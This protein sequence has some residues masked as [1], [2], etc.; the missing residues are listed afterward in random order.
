[1]VVSIIKVKDEGEALRVAN[2]ASYGLSAAV[3]TRDVTFYS[4]YGWHPRSV[5]AAIASL[6]DV[7]ANRVRL[8]ARVAEMSEYFRVRLQ[9]LEFDRPVAVRIRGLAIGIHVEDEN[10]A[11][12][13][14]TCAAATGCSYRPK[15]RP[16]CCCRRW[17]RKAD[18]R[19]RLD[20]LARSI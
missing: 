14:I 20:I 5:A 7:K 3:F 11:T 6:R 18:G 12:P 9:P 17:H 19:E 1:V 4:T 10:Y 2:D 16:C 15:D 13:F 8:L